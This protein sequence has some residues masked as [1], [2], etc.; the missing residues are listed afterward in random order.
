MVPPLQSPLPSCQNLSLSPIH[1]QN[2][3]TSGEP[4]QSRRYIVQTDGLPSHWLTPSTRDSASLSHNLRVIEPTTTKKSGTQ[5]RVQST[6]NIKDKNHKTL[7][8]RSRPLFPLF[9]DKRLSSLASKKRKSITSPIHHRSIKDKTNHRY[10]NDS[11][12][13]SFNH[14]PLSRSPRP[15]P[16]LPCNASSLVIKSRRQRRTISETITHRAIDDKPNHRPLDDSST[17]SSTPESLLRSPR[18]NSP[19]PFNDGNLVNKSR[20]HRNNLPRINYSELEPQ[21]DDQDSSDYLAVASTLAAELR[22]D[23]DSIGWEHFVRGR[24][25]LSFTPI[26]AD[27]Y[28]ANKLGRRFTTKKWFSTVIASLFEIHQQ[29]WGEFCSATSRTD[30]TNKISSPQKKTL[31]CLVESYYKLSG[32][33]RKLQRNWFARPINSFSSWTVDELRY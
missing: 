9:Q 12:T 24:L 15:H 14:E 33:L 2:Q 8:S 4:L 13:L 3:T 20:R 21:D 25:S 32:T 31:L 1:P 16:S 23:Q 18:L 26:I 30:S 27:Y 28:R 19:A 11:S 5:T 6:I 29:A 7:L 17:L 22:T 10:L